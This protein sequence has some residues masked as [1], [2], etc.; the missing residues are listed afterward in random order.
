MKKFCFFVSKPVFSFLFVSFAL[1]A[2]FPLY[3]AESTTKK[4]W[5][6]AAEKFVLTQKNSSKAMQSVC[7]SLPSLI[8]EQF[9]ENLERRI[10]GE[11]ELDRILYDL[12]KTRTSLFLQLSK[13]VQTRDAL[14]LNDYSEKQLK[15]K[16]KESEKKIKSIQDQIFENLK[17][18]RTQT[19]KYKEQIE[20]DKNRRKSIDEGGV[21][22]VEKEKNKFASLFLEMA[23]KAGDETTVENVVL[24]QN[25]STKLFDAGSEKQSQ[26][27]SSQVFESACVNA[28]INALITGKITVYGSYL[29]C[30]VSIYQYPGSKLIASA[31]DVG[32]FENLRQLA[33]SLSMQISPKISESMP[34]ELNICVEPQEA[35]KNLVFTVDGISF[36]DIDRPVIVQGGVHSLSFSSKG[37]DTVS[38]NFSFFGNRKFKIDV[39]LKESVSGSVNLRLKKAYTGDIFANGIFSGSVTDENPYGNIKI[40]GNDVLGHFIDSNGLSAD[41]IIPQKLLNDNSSFFVDLKPL[42]RSE[43]IEK[44]RRWMYAGYSALIVSLI[45]TFYIYGNSYAKTQAYNTGANISYEEAKSWQSASN[46]MTGVSV[47]AGVFFVYELVRYLFAAEN[48]LPKT[49]KTISKKQ[50]KKFLLQDEKVLLKKNATESGGVVESE[51]EILKQV[52]NDNGAE[53]NDNNENTEVINIE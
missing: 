10:Y 17:E 4:N 37:Y 3:S 39:Q 36:K 53:R 45:P 22:E 11:E 32:S 18:G 52:R 47:S 44:R 51:E 31:M 1:F 28:G 19:E 12:R 24:Y 13:E 7:S 25:D 21:I 6:L 40:N 46:I 16:I 33:T 43:Y 38:T 14:L 48:V 35:V 50:E 41:F 42:D 23:K 49:A 27:Y 5:T 26:G 2:C 30:A 29:S 8:L 34:V 20:N 9:S 15:E